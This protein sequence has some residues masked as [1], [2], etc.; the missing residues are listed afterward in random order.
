VPLCHWQNT[1]NRN[2]TIHIPRFSSATQAQL[3]AVS[4]NAQNMYQTTLK[5]TYKTLP[6][7][8]TLMSSNTAAAAIYI[9]HPTELSSIQTQNKNPVDIT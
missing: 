4:Y 2:P 9:Q 8:A 1:Q 3:E 7:N 6:T 5:R